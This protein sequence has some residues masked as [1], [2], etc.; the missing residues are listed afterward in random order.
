MRKALI[1]A[2]VLC[3]AMCAFLL[4][5]RRSERTTNRVA[6]EGH[7]STEPKRG[8]SCRT[9]TDADGHTYN[10]S[11]FVPYGMTDDDQ[12]P[13]IVNLNGFGENGTDGKAPLIAGL[14]P[15][16]WEMQ[17][18]F[19]FVAVFP[20]CQS[21][22][23]WEAG[24]A[25]ADRAI[26]IL[27]KTA[28]EYHTDSD[29][30]Y[31][32]GLSSGGSG[33]WSIAAAHPH[34]FAA[35]IPFSAGRVISSD[36]AK[37]IAEAHLPVWSFYVKGDAGVDSANQTVERMLIDA[38]LS[39]RFTQL[40]SGADDADHHNAW[41]F[42]YRNSGLYEWLSEQRSS[43]N[44]R[45]QKPFTTLL[46]ATGVNRWKADGNG[47]WHFTS[48]GVLVAESDGTNARMSLT[49][50]AFPH[51]LEIHVEFRADAGM[52]C[53]IGFDTPREDAPPEGW[54]LQIVP[55]E[56]GSGG[57]RLLKS[58]KW[59]QATNPAAQ[60][61]LNL[62]EWNDLRIRS[63]DDR[64]TASLNGWKLNDLQ[65]PR[66]HRDRGDIFLSVS[67][68]SEA[69]AAQWRNLR[70]R[71]I[72][73]PLSYS[74]SQMQ[75]VDLRDAPTDVTVEQVFA[76]WSA[77][78]QRVLDAQ[79]R[80]KSDW[81]EAVGLSEFLAGI[82]STDPSLEAQSNTALLHQSTVRF[83][84]TWWNRE[85]PT[86]RGGR[87]ITLRDDPKYQRLVATCFKSQPTTPMQYS[88]ILNEAERVDYTADWQGESRRAD[89]QSLT[90][91]AGTVDGNLKDLFHSPLQ[92][93]FRPLSPCG[94]GIVP[95]DC[96]IVAQASFA[97]GVD[98]VLVEESRGQDDQRL[99]R[100]FWVDPQRDFVVVRYIGQRGG[101]S[102]E[103]L[104]VQYERYEHQ[105][106]LPSRW[107][108][109]TPTN[110][111]TGAFV[112]RFPGQGRLFEHAAAIAVDWSINEPNQQQPNLSVLPAGTTVR[113]R[114][115][116][117]WYTIASDGSKQ[118]LD[119][120]A[121][122]DTTLASDA[123]GE[124]ESG[125]AVGWRLVCG[126]IASIIL[127]SYIAW[128]RRCAFPTRPVPKPGRNNA[129]R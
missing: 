85:V 21:G 127:A 66:L 99:T 96:R 117:E 107:S 51:N 9:Y 86:T 88:I 50:N 31:L 60:R 47:N 48:D 53:G 92:L 59:L 18:C 45:Q 6:S 95:K 15:S 73:E 113:D 126:G 40:E 7:V 20:Q 39:P 44:R 30:V 58:G 80:W 4:I 82:V 72:D 32:T 100:R 1:A 3:L 37:A 10:Y 102:K 34:L 63:V 75:T 23:T 77:R 25:A 55:S 129:D 57:I 81:H 76:A 79:L 106:W 46:D 67:S 56:D 49:S 123:P 122:V 70:W 120:D 65:D 29:R 33:V 116:N 38:G 41:D 98:C 36:Q 27:Q 103:Q 118:T 28:K 24:G 93:V 91:A 121:L 94:F 13:L 22:E 83:D 78:E 14:A 125:W 112:S 109:I 54:E 90:H 89:V 68:T 43:N 19:P 104:D 69:T 124:S 42:G 11:V 110:P 97:N 62:R 2:S 61:T 115:T 64:V 87:P 12:L 114:L 74:E 111:V 5:A 16:I 8:F 105:R 101:V 119:R 17:R 84:T 108:A 128:R 71:E 35:L 26:Q 52:T